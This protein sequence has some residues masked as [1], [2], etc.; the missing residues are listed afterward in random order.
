M[1]AGSKFENNV[2]SMDTSEIA[3]RRALEA[4][5]VNKMLRAENTDGNQKPF[6]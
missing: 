2:H 5:P 6:R 1:V 3:A 4:S